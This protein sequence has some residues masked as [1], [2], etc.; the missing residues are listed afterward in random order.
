MIYAYKC[1][2]GAF[3]MRGEE[4]PIISVPFYNP[5]RSNC[6]DCGREAKGDLRDFSNAPRSNLDEWG[7]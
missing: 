7:P 3:W 1:K 6:P 2:C 4:E 5:H